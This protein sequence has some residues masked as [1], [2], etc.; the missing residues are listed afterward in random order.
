MAL[1]VILLLGVAA[2]FVA[3]NLWLRSRH[4]E[5]LAAAAPAPTPTPAIAKGDTPTIRLGD[6]Q[7]IDRLHKVLTMRVGEQVDLLSMTF[8]GIPRLR[9]VLAGVELAPADDRFPAARDCARIHLELGGAIAGCGTLVKEIAVNQFLVPLATQDEQR[10][11]ILH[12][13]GKDDIV[14]FL[15]IKVPHLNVEGSTAE[16]DVLHVSGHWAG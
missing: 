12:F 14:S 16:V 8:D 7:R 9:V 13:H 15:R 3:T 2:V 5:T 6:S 1:T 10:C 4:G 11:S